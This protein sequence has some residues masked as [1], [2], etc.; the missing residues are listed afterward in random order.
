MET[1]SLLSKE[2]HTV[3]RK[4]QLLEEASI[5]L[6]EKK[7]I[8]EPEL[9][10]VNDFLEFFRF[11]MV[12]HFRIEAQ[13]L[14]PALKNASNSNEK[15]ILELLS[16]HQAILQKYSTLGKLRD[17]RIDGTEQLLDFLKSLSD[18]T[19]KE[20]ELLPPLIERLDQK[21]L[22]MIDEKAKSLGYPIL[23]A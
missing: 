4:I 22:R 5:N 21:Q 12:Q 6:L 23:I 17:Q 14:F 7:F 18:H 1:W 20:E 19:R 16:E 8:N 11:G 2:H 10:P 15:L 3:F 13:T 9:S